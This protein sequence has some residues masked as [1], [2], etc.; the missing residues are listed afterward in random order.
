[1]RL[2]I[3]AASMVSL[4]CF[5]QTTFNPNSLSQSGSYFTDNAV[6]ASGSL[7]NEGGRTTYLDAQGIPAGSS[8]RIGDTVYFRDAM[9]IPAGRAQ[10]IGDR[11]YF[12]GADGIPAGS[13]LSSGSGPFGR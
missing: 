10:T 2:A 8:Q 5:A 3:L 13:A 6:V 12:T 1:M 9:G 4:G 7:T 11:T